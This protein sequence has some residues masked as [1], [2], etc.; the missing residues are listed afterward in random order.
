MVTSPPIQLM[1]FYKTTR[2]R[3][4]YK[5]AIHWLTHLTFLLSTPEGTEIVILYTTAH[6]QTQHLKLRSI[7]HITSQT[8]GAPS[9][10]T[11][12]QRGTFDK[13]RKYKTL[14]SKHPYVI[15]QTSCY[16]LKDKVVFEGEI[17]KSLRVKTKSLKK[18]TS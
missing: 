4:E 7:H 11:L 16:R 3:K 6:C 2:S 12:S 9:W 13:R 10:S 5:S 1:R 8:I 14:I 17:F 15:A 18:L